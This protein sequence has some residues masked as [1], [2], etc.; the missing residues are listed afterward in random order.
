MWRTFERSE[1]EGWKHFLFGSTT[2]TLDRLAARVN[3]RFPHVDIVGTH[4]PPHAT[5]DPDDADRAAV[6]AID[7]ARPDILWVGLGTPKQERWM[8]GHV[9]RVAA[10]V[11]VGVGAAID[12]HAGVKRQAPPWM[13]QAGLEW[14][15]RM[16]TEPR[17][18][19][20]RYL[21]N[22]PRFVWLV[23]QQLLRGTD[24][25]RSM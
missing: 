7:A 25:S 2:D 4:S 16:A 17:R 20:G 13:R 5:S 23:A 24:V 21:R 9:G 11:L 1:T 18:L 14:A 15:F 22:N 3:E 10:P 6:E 8:A 19:A 12:F